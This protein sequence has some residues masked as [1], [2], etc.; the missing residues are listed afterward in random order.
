F[1][2]AGLDEDAIHES[3]KLSL[4]RIVQEQLNNISKYAKATRV[5]IA[6]SNDTNEVSLQICDNGIGFN[7]KDKRVGVG[8]TNIYNRVESYNGVVDLRSSPGQ[9]CNLHIWIPLHQ[10]LPF[11]QN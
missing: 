10:P 7:T 3:I 11:I 5:T 4:F 2:F 1:S 8:L 6:I 9:G